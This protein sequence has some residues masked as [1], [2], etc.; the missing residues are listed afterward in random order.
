MSETPEE[1]P[2]VGEEDIG[3]APMEQGSLF[4]PV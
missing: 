4:H 1:T 3:A 2:M